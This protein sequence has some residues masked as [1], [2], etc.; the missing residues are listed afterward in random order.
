[1]TLPSRLPHRLVIGAVIAVVAL[2]ACGKD[3]NITKTPVRS[4]CSPCATPTTTAPWYSD[5]GTGTPAG[6]IA[7][8]GA[9]PITITPHPTATFNPFPG[10]GGVHIPYPGNGFGPTRCA[11]GSISGSAGQGTCS[12][13]GGESG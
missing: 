12:W 7:P 6:N 11:D 8:P 9:S 3:P 5:Q 13:H 10:T 2:T 1:M 4:A